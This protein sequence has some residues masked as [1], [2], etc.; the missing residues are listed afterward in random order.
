MENTSK[1]LATAEEVSES[2]GLHRVAVALLAAAG[3]FPGPDGICLSVPTAGQAGAVFRVTS[4]AIFDWASR[5]AP[6]R[7]AKNGKGD[8][9]LGRL[10]AW[11]RAQAD[12]TSW[13]PTER[14]R[15]RHTGDVLRGLLWAIHGHSEAWLAHNRHAF[16]DACGGNEE[17]A[18]RLLCRALALVEPFDCDPADAEA[19]VEQVWDVG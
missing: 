8:Y 9:P 13:Q 16:V 18:T 17:K 2:T 5:G 1:Q 12:G 7:G 3:Q 4:K 14:P 19:V 10:L 11:R 6:C 15:V